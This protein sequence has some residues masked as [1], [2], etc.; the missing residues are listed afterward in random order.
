MNSLIREDA[1]KEEIT[2]LVSDMSFAMKEDHAEQKRQGYKVGRFSLSMYHNLIAQSY[3]R[4]GNSTMLSV[5]RVTA[6]AQRSGTRLNESLVSVRDA[7]RI[8]RLLLVDLGG[9][10]WSHTREAIKNAGPKFAG[11]LDLAHPPIPAKDQLSKKK[12][13]D[14][15]N[16]EIPL[17]LL[18][19]RYALEVAELEVKVE[20][21]ARIKETAGPL[22]PLAVSLI[23]RMGDI[24]D[25]SLKQE[26][27]GLKQ[28]IEN[29]KDKQFKLS[30]YPV[31]SREDTL[32]A[33]VSRLEQIA[34]E[35]K[36]PVP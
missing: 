13:P 23:D 24:K 11:L 36:L 8:V 12:V 32:A 5:A 28:F 7:E 27:A 34:V 14:G 31:P 6:K 22:E 19:H 16:S 29:S 20:K 30:T 4:G 3:R 25:P 17:S 33:I 9:Y 2:L 18:L 1:T 15:S 35:Q 26:L 10:G 21:E